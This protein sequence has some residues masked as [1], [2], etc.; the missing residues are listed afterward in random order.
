M[1]N[2]LHSNL[3]SIREFY[4]KEWKPTLIG[5]ITSFLIGYFIIPLI[6]DFVGLR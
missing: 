5:I 4:I 2:Y 3:S 6:L 1:L